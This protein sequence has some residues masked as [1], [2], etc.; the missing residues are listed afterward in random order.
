MILQNIF[1]R[2]LPKG[3]VVWCLGLPYTKESFL[4]CCGEDVKSDFIDSLELQYNSM[5]ADIIWSYY[6]Q[7]AKK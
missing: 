7:T 3:Q 5:D 4:F 2:K 6:E 1:I